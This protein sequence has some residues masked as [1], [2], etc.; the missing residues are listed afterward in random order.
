LSMDIFDCPGPFSFFGDFPVMR[1][2]FHFLFSFYSLFLS[3]FLLGRDITVPM[4]YTTVSHEIYSPYTMSRP[5]PQK[6]RRRTSRDLPNLTGHM[7]FSGLSRL[8]AESLTITVPESGQLAPSPS[9][10]FWKEVRW[11][12][13]WVFHSTW[14][15]NRRFLGNFPFNSWPRRPWFEFESGTVNITLSEGKLAGHWN[16][17]AKY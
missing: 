10:D 13:D 11:Q 7:A 16:P 2:T 9:T 4:T 15:P 8:S 17:T 6:P 5:A 12:F 3:F 1:L 14:K